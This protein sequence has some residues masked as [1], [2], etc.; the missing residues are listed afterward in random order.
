[1]EVPIQAE[2]VRLDGLSAHADRNQI[3]SWLG[4]PEHLRRAFI[5]HGE[6]GPS[7]ALAGLLAE[8][9][10]GEVTIPRQDAVEEL[11]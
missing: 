5:V 4:G 6:P 1:M 7:Q 2:V 11:T 9:A 8:R 3:A 10:L